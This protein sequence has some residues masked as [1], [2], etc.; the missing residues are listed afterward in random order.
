MVLPS[1]SASGNHLVVVAAG[2]QV[3]GNLVAVECTA[4]SVVNERVDEQVDTEIAGDE[5]VVRE[6]SKAK[7]CYSNRIGASNNPRASE[8]EREEESRR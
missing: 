3:V 5:E 7:A 1:L 2:C 6:V 8:W 4:S